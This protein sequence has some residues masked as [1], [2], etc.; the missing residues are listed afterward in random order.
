[1]SKVSGQTLTTKVFRCPKSSTNSVCN[2]ECIESINS[3][4]CCCYRCYFIL[5][6]AK[7]VDYSIKQHVQR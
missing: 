5:C 7:F 6:S 4:F 3:T 2:S 1:M